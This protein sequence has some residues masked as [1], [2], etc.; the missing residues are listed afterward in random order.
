MAKKKQRKKVYKVPVAKLRT[1]FN[2]PE[3]GRKNVVEVHFSKRDNR[4]Y[5]RC[6]ACGEGYE[7]DIKRA[8]LPIDI[9]YNWINQ[10]DL[11]KERAKSDK[12]GNEYDDEEEVEENDNRDYEQQE[13]DNNNESEEQYKGK[14]DP[15]GEEEDDEY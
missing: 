5:I 14:E 4:G 6:R 3:C 13:N 15:V 8:S 10:R 7:G 1:Q 9:Y 12:N 2:C 11:E